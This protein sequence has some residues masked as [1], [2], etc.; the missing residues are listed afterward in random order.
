MIK[1][2]KLERRQAGK[3]PPPF[4]VKAPNLLSSKMYLSTLVVTQLHSRSILS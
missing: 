2:L 1:K 3:P 4:H